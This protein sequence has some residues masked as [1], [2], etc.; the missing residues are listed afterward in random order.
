MALAALNGS[1]LTDTFQLQGNLYVRGF[2]QNHTDGIPPTS[3][4]AAGTPARI[5][6]AVSAWRMT[7]FR[8]EP[9]D[10]RLPRPVRNRSIQ[11]NAPCPPG[12]VCN[13]VPDGQS[14]AQRPRRP[15]PAF[16]CRQPVPTGC[17][18]IKTTSW[19]A[20][21]SITA[22]PIS[23]AVSELG[24]LYPDL[25]V[26]TNPAIPGSGA[27]IHT[28]WR[29][30]IWSGRRETRNTYYGLYALNTL[31][32]TERPRRPR[33]PAEYCRDRAERPV[34]AS[35]DLNGDHTYTH[36]VQP[37][38]RADL[39]ADPEPHRVWRRSEATG[40]R[41]RSNWPAPTR[42]GPVCRKTRSSPSAAEQVVARTFEV[43]LRDRLSF[44][45]ASL[46][47]RPRCSARIPTTI[48]SAS[49]AYLGTRLF[50]E[51]SGHPPSRRRGQSEIPSRQSA[52]LC[53]FQLPRCDIPVHWR[54]PVSEQSDGRRRGERD[55]GTGK[56]DSGHPSI[57]GERRV[58]I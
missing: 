29:L 52:G 39:Q 48:L 7:G 30:R 31:D 12:I 46:D 47:G 5:F 54:S 58:R 42:F 41:L 44:D 2:R 24:Y 20:A 4:N 23:P 50:S 8:P 32:V 26:A 21:A 55:V 16:R 57:S 37:G 56:R 28:S 19:P 3:S 10:H 9:G 17:S 36:W 53:R 1:S 22:A 6:R 25:V 34:G 11:Q 43:G 38:N 27:A 40:A 13:D 35:P 33:R 49:P 51:C 14:T 18:G 45:E 15:R